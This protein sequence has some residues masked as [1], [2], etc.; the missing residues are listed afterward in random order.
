M[1]FTFH[2]MV[3]LCTLPTYNII[4]RFEVAGMTLTSLYSHMLKIEKK[5]LYVHV[6][7]CMLFEWWL[8]S[9]YTIMFR[10][11]WNIDWKHFALRIHHKMEI[12]AIGYQKSSSHLYNLNKQNIKHTRFKAWI[13]TN[14]DQNIQLQWRLIQDQNLDCD[15]RKYRPWTLSK[16][17]HFLLVP[18]GRFIWSHV[19][20]LLINNLCSR[21]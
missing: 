1:S 10:G 13:Y 14:L 18:N 3:S 12:D 8:V 21:D 2:G 4:F 20:A 11:F 15:T 16:W 17:Q 7:I 19:H 9:S 6:Y 5:Q